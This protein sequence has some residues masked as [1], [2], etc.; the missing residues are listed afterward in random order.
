MHEV[1][2]LRP[3]F[4]ASLRTTRLDRANALASRGSFRQAL[5]AVQEVLKEN[6]RDA[7]AQK[8]EKHIQ[9]LEAASRFG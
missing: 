1:K 3:V 2:R 4:K 7:E 9:L 8:L 6:P 5:R